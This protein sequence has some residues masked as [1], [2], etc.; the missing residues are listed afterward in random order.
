MRIVGFG[1]G[2]HWCTEGVFQSLKG[3]S[4]VR[5]G[6]ISSDGENE[7]FSE[8]VIVRFNPELISLKSLIE[9]HLYT[10]SSTSNH[11]MRDKYRSAVYSDSEVH[12]AEIET[13]IQSF[14]K[15]FDEA[16]I[17]RSLS[18]VEFK[19]NKEEYLN[20]LYSRPDAQFCKTYIHPKLYLLME[21]FSAE[22]NPKQLSKI[23]GLFPR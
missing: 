18:L 8:G 12:R 1:G 11:S 19:E 23:E 16:I 6:W 13:I 14:Q 20:Y 17:T 5:Q 21:R 9:I 4:N 10:H 7:S 3:I 2:C 15:D 22:V